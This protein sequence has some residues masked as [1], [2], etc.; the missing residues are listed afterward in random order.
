MQTVIMVFFYLQILTLYQTTQSPLLEV[1][2]MVMVL[3]YNQIQDLTLYQTTQS[4]LVEN[5][6]LVST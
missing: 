3:F 4:Q 1:E 5:M 2:M 6:L